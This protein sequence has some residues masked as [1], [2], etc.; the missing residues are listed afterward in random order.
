MCP[1]KRV[2]T[3]EQSENKKVHGTLCAENHECHAGTRLPAEFGVQPHIKC[4]DNRAGHADLRFNRW[5]AAR[6]CGNALQAE[7]GINI[8]VM[9]T[10]TLLCTMASAIILLGMASCEKQ[11]GSRYVRFKAVTRSDPQTRAAFS[12][13][14]FNNIE[15]INWEANDRIV[16]YMTNNEHPQGINAQYT[17]TDITPDAPYSKGKLEAATANQGLQWGTGDHTF[18][19]V[20]PANTT[21]ND[22]SSFSGTVSSAQSGSQISVADLDPSTYIEAS[23][24]FYPSNQNMY[25][26]AYNAGIAETATDVIL[27]FSPAFTTFHISATVPQTMT[28]KCVRLVADAHADYSPLA[29]SF[30][31]TYDLGESEWSFSS[32]STT[33][34]IR[35]SLGNGSGIAF[36]QDDVV[37]IVLLALPLEL[38]GLTLYFDLVIPGAASGDT[39]IEVTRSLPLRVPSA[40]LLYGHQLQADDWIIFN[41]CKQ[42][43]IK[44]LLIPGWDWTADGTT[45]VRMRETVAPWEDESSSL[46]YKNGQ[47]PVVNAT[48]LSGSLSS[49][50]EFSIF[51]PAG[52]EWLIEVLDNNGVNVDQNVTITQLDEGGST[53]QSGSGSLSGT[54]GDPSRI[55]FSLTGVTSNSLSFSV[56]VDGTKYSINSEVARI[57]GPLPI[58]SN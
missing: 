4:Q 39:P 45:T 53:L 56:V 14:V 32:S 34:E 51:S 26:C 6:D 1:G 28:I 48:K 15:R 19:G 18:L 30:S 52:Q 42:A 17:I 41:A 20:Y 25:L 12:G 11:P 55:R 44:G 37:D 36:S 16:L 46:D 24:I 54:I 43:Y 13:L 49:G 31:G 35:F 57:N 10:K 23:T 8:R 9:R 3:D 27:D 5:V 7:L 21:V 22:L 47:D 38:S 29:G 33:K 40:T 2:K 58:T 50:F